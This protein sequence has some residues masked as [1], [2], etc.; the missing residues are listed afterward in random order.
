MLLSTY[1]K[2]LGTVSAPA[3]A[4]LLRRKKQCARTADPAWAPAITA[5]TAR[6]VFGKIAN[7]RAPGVCR[8]QTE[9]IYQAV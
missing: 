7:M 6:I 5:I 1:G 8:G 2:F 4:G 3:H 9:G